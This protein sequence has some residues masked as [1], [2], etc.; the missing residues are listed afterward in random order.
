M[1]PPVL[2]VAWPSTPLTALTHLPLLALPSAASYA[3]LPILYD[4]YKAAAPADNLVPFLGLLLA[5]RITLYACALATVFVAAQRSGDA[6]AGLG[7]RFERITAEAISPLTMPEEQTA[8]VRAVAQTLDATPQA[9]QA[10]GLPVVFGA[11]LFGAYVFNL[12]V[13]STPPPPPDPEATDAILESLRSAFATIQPLSTAS[14]CVFACNVEAQ[15]FAAGLINGGQSFANS[16]DLSPDGSTSGEI[17]LAPAS[18]AA[19]AAA[20]TCVA[21]AYV[22]PPAS[23]WPLQNTIN[24]CI[25][26]GVARVLQIPSLPALLA[27]VGGLALYDGVG[28]LFAA[29]AAE[30]EVIVQ[31]SSS[32]MESVAKAKLGATVGGVQAWQ[33]GLL[34]VLLQGRLTDAL[35]L[36]DV[37]APALIAGWC[38]RFDLRLEAVDGAASDDAG[39]NGGGGGSYLGAA[40]SGY[41]IGCV[42][43]EVVP[44]ELSRAAL[45]FLVPSTTA[46][47]LIRLVERK[48]LQMAIAPDAPSSED[49]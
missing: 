34:T 31:S 43:L 18:V 9:A 29:T 45:L 20:L 26:I 6:P 4:T 42:L 12:L 5:K 30:P 2:E 14:V 17:E 16:A 7:E 41:A 47:V 3:T 40:L 39:S 19:A 44:A 27:A 37:V 15:A 49:A 1:R 10:A 38:R 13:A 33:P 28:T 21:L 35:G 8:E 22:V 46:S 11:L 24:A 23:A 32:V 25:A 48:E 36:G